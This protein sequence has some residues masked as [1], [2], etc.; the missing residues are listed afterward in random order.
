MTTRTWQSFMKKVRAKY[1]LWPFRYLYSDPS[2]TYWFN[3]LVSSPKLAYSH[4]GDS[5]LPDVS[6]H[7][8]TVN[9]LQRTQQSD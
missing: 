7:L 9:Y 2:L 8:I 3:T 6:K 4:R 1:F 5:P